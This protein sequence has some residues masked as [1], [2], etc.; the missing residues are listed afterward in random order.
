MTAVPRGA[1]RTVSLALAALV[2]ATALAAT[3][4]GSLQNA[5]E[6]SADCAKCHAFV[7]PAGHAGEP[8]VSP[9]AWA[10]GMMANAARD[11]VFWAGVAIAAQDMPGETS[12]CVRCHSPRAFLAGRDDATAIDDLEPD[13]LAGIDCDLCHRMIDDGMTPLG[14]AHYT[15]DDVV[16][17]AGDVPKQGPWSYDGGDKPM[18]SWVV[19]DLL[20]RSEHCGTCHDVTTGRDRLDAQGQPIG[21]KFNEQRTYS[22]WLASAYAVEGA[23]FKSCQDCHM[24]AVDNVAGCAEF[25]SQEIFHATDG[26]RHDLAGANRRMVEILQSLYGEAGSGDIDDA[27]FE[28]ALANIDSSLGAAATLE[29]TA[30]T[31]IDLQAGVAAWGVKVTNNTGHKLPTGYSEGR[32]MWLEITA[33]YMGQVVYGSGRWLPGQGLEN[34]PQQRTYEAIAVQQQS[35]TTF[36]LLL[37]D[38]WQVDSRIPPKGL[39][40]GVET[41]P[42]GDR[43]TMLPDETWPHWDEVTYAFDPAE[44]VDLTPGEDDVLDLRV[45]LL[46]VINTP[47]YLEFLASENVTN[48]AGADAQALFP[49]EPDPL[50]LAEWTASVPATGLVEEAT[51]SSS[52]DEP[53]TGPSPTTDAPTTSAGTGTT[54]DT[55]ANP[56]SSSGDATDSATTSPQTPTDEGCGCRQSGPGGALALLLL[57]GLRRRRR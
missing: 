15:I 20:G 31:T 8:N 3:E 36:H 52:G 1:W 6:K 2:P 17:E 16:G 23:E 35:G 44:V 24:P 37:N 27:Y 46:Y 53:T 12:S 30:P 14:D 5:L 40:A 13:D 47:A 54:A 34:D 11:P 38:Y 49:A 29:V 4:P 56:T 43:Y 7:N 39:Q 41:D 10:G 57:A 22:E 48:S 18:H 55:T 50:V 9:I 26:R 51:T 45:R 21:A 25:N 19:G 28:L 32:V 33:S 42:V